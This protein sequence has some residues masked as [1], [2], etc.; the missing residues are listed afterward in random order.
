MTVQYYIFV[1]PLDPQSSPVMY[2]PWLY[3]STQFSQ[4]VT[5]NYSSQTFC[6]V[7]SHIIVDYGCAF[8]VCSERFTHTLV[9]LWE[10]LVSMHHNDPY[11]FS[12]FHYVLTTPTIQQFTACSVALDRSHCGLDRHLNVKGKSKRRGGLMNGYTLLPSQC[13]K[14]MNHS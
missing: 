1:L 7:K 13:T 3:W 9:L 11:L 6:P 5:D 4:I 10:R 14:E 2:S 12:N 8:I